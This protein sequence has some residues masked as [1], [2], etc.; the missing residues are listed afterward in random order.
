MIC[1]RSGRKC[2]NLGGIL[3]KI[4]VLSLTLL[5]LFQPLRILVPVIHL[6][7]SS[8]FSSSSTSLYYFFSLILCFYS[9]PSSSTLQ[10]Y[11]ISAEHVGEIATPPSSFLFLSRFPSSNPWQYLFWRSLT[12]SSSSRRSKYVVWTTGI[13]QQPVASIW[14]SFLKVT[15][16]LP[17]WSFGSRENKGSIAAIAFIP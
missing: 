7:L 9:P 15:S 13:K 12:C 5:L 14:T 8:S 3:P 6:L 11:W 4:A 2:R 1:C 16:S 17:L 10:W